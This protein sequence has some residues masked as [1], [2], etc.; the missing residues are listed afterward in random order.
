M[1][2]R[3]EGLAARLTSRVLDGKGELPAEIRRAA[4]AGE[5]VPEALSAYVSKVR[6]RAYTVMD[7][8]VEALLA[9]GYSEDQLFELTVAAA[10]G[11]GCSRLTA[12]LRAME[13]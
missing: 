5:E 12:G 3:F 6:Q 13:G 4:F 2:D 8:D 1:K 9:A 11:A 10:L 7:E